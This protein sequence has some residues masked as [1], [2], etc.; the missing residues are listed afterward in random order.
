MLEA[1]NAV[2]DVV[3]VED[4]ARRRRWP[5]PLAFNGVDVICLF[6]SIFG[7]G[8]IVVAAGEVRTLIKPLGPILVVRQ[9]LVGEL[10][11]DVIDAATGLPQPMVRVTAA[12]VELP[13][14]EVLLQGKRCLCREGV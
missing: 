10:G 11:E 9:R 3:P 1:A 4:P 12:S 14:Q 5:E 7:Q 2:L 6:E 8:I 13:A